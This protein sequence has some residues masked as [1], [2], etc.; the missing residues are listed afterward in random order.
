MLLRYGAAAKGASVPAVPNF[1]GRGRCGLGSNSKR[2]GNGR[3]IGAYA[4]PGHC[5]NAGRSSGSHLRR[6]RTLGPGREDGEA[7]P[8]TLGIPPLPKTT[9]I[10]TAEKIRSEFANP[11]ACSG[12]GLHNPTGLR[13]TGRLVGRSHGAQKSSCRMADSWVG[14]T[15]MP[16][17]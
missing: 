3:R 16:L 10:V 5:W 7:R 9:E 2:R 15:I 1:R 8:P 13:A 11:S 6:Q 17:S 14:L 12:L 4:G